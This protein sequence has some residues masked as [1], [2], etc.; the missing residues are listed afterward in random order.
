MGDIHKTMTPEAQEANRTNGAKTKGPESEQGKERSKMNAL[1]NG[2]YARRPDP[3]ELLRKDHTEEEEAEREE[4]RADAVRCY[5][6]PDEFARRQAEEMADLQFE[7]RRLERAKEV[8][9]ARERELLAL[10]QRKRSLR[11]KPDFA[12]TTAAA[13][14]DRRLL[15]QPDSPGKFREMLSILESLV[16]EDCEVNDARKLVQRLY[17]EGDGPWRGARLG[18]VLNLVE[19]AESDEDCERASQEFDREVER[20]IERVREEL[21][22]C[23]LQQGPLSPAGEAARLLEAMGSRKWAWMRQHEMFLRRSIDRKVQVLIKLRGQAQ[24]SEDES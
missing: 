5:Q 21:A 17:G 2:K 16:Q 19:S 1:K 14:Y 10:E 7:L 24:R 9:L 12:E 18:W 22:I 23:E 6:P 4:L 20:E 8:M 15:V 3:V 13:V 11:L